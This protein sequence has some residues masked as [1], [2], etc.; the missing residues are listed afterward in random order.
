MFLNLKTNIN[1][2]ELIREKNIL[3]NKNGLNCN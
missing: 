1:E 3:K 2:E